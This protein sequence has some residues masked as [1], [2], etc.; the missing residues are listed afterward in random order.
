[1][2]QPTLFNLHPNE[3]SNH[4][5]LVNLDKCV[6]SFNTLNDL[7]NEVCVPNETEDLYLSGFN[8]IAEINEPNILTKHVSCK[9][10]CKFCG[11][12]CN[13]N[14]KW[15]NDKCRCKRKSVTE[16]HVYEKDD[17]WNPATCSCLNF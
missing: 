17:I 14:Q 11:K 3:Y 5:S 15:N 7:P 13:S 9:R 10:E 1:M 8:M 2:T 16:Q 4:P 12:N 6:G